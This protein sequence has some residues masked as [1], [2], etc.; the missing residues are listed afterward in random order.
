[1]GDKK[2]KNGIEAESGVP[3]KFTLRI[4]TDDDPDIDELTVEQ[5]EAYLAEL[6]NQ[7]DELDANE[8]EDDGSNAYDEWADQHE[9]L[10]DLIDEVEDRL[11]ELR[12]WVK[13][14]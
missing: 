1:M 8:P 7:L 5:L 14:Y 6:E 13:L 2:K 9:E 11:E 3:I 4:S 10:E 12:G